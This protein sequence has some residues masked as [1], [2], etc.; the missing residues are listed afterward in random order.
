MLLCFTTQVQSA[1]IPEFIPLV[2]KN[3]ESV[4]NISTTQRIQ[5]KTASKPGPIIPGI[6]ESSPLNDFLRYLISPN[7]Q[8][9]QNPRELNSQPLGSGF[10]ISTDGYILTNAHVISSATQ[11]LVRLSDQ[12]ELV[13]EL[14]GTDK[15]TDVALLKIDEHDLPAVQIS[16]SDK[17]EIGQW[18]LAIGSPFG[19][20]HTAS[21]GIISG[22]GRNLPHDTYVPFIQ[23]DVAINPG[24]SGGP[25]FDLNGNVIGINSQIL[26]KSGGSIGLSFAIPINV[27]LNVAQQLRKNGKV[28]RGWLGMNAQDLT[29]NL[30]TSF[31]LKAPVGALISG[32]LQSS[33]ADEAGIQA[34]D[35]IIEFNGKP[36]ERATELLQY[37]GFTQLN[38]EV[39][40]KLLRDGET[41]TTEVKII[42]LT[43]AAA[44]EVALAE[45]SDLSIKSLKIKINEL[46]MDHRR[47]LNVP[48]NGVL[49]KAVYRGP[50][51]KSGIH[52]GDVIM[53]INHKKVENTRHFLKLVKSLPLDKPVS[54][55]LRRKQGPVYVSVTIP[56]GDK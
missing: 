31:G 22:L 55:L 24:N 30:A 52:K 12:R 16:N 9:Q 37:V 25:L 43:D 36:V 1:V 45:S 19:F 10:I 48:K 8:K 15:L 47:F 13:A 23:T 20:D 51:S 18:V 46:S 21:Q 11:I 32:V 50:A 27:A 35:I 33:P 6:D 53:N 34:G 40:V 5:A 38:T 4:V 42:E 26:T 7:R 3:Y 54:V 28:T 44:T 41:L 2:K 56:S 39:P 29:Q 17:L 14:I 49:V